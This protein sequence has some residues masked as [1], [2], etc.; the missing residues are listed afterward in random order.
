[1]AISLN[2]N[3]KINAGKP[4]DVKYLR[5]DNTPYTS[6]S[7]VNSSISA[8]E[9]HIGLTVNINGTEY[10]YNSGITDG[11]L[12]EKQTSLDGTYIT[13]ATNIGF[14]SGNTGVMTL[15]IQMVSFEN[16]SG[17]YRSQ[18]GYFYRSCDNKICVGTPTYDCINRR[19]FVKSGDTAM[20]F[21]WNESRCGNDEIGWGLIEGDVNELIGCSVELALPLYYEGGLSPYL[22][23]GFTTTI[24]Y[25]NGSNLIIQPVEGS[26][27]TGDIITI[28][29]RPYIETN[30]NVLGF[31]SIISDTPNVVNVTDDGAFIRLS[32]NSNI[33]NT[34]TASNISVSGGTGI[35]SG[36]T[37]NVLYFKPLIPSGNTIIVDNGDSVIINTDSPNPTYD[38][39]TPS[40]ITLGGIT[41][42]T[43]LT[44][45]TSFELFEMLLFPTLYPTLTP[46]SST[47]SL[48]VNSSPAASV[49]EI[50]CVLGNTCLVTSYNRGCINP[51]YT[52]ASDKR[53]CGSIGYSLTGDS[54]SG[55]CILNSLSL[56]N[57]ISGY[58]VESGTHTWSSQVCYCEGVQPY[59]NKENPYC[60][61]LSRGMTSARSVSFN[62]ILPWYWGLSSSFIINGTC[63][64]SCG[65]NGL[66]SKNLANVTSSP[67]SITFNSSS[68]DYLWFALP[69]CAAEKTCWYIPN[70]SSKGSIG[71]AES[72][73]ASYCT[74]NVTSAEGCW[75]S[76][77]Y[78]V[79]VSNYTTATEA[80]VA[81][82]IC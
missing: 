50:G 24:S 82:Y 69:A 18:Y 63:I 29:A 56:C 78:E 39:S 28:G 36:M 62:G 72:L 32:G 38:L 49:Y 4:I 3:I 22:N 61:P 25:N 40:S 16:Y 51:Q 19:G 58:V 12:I 43:T 30:D 1:M 23:T 44:G 13:G 67:I 15:P 55:Y 64:A 45:K 77:E 80:G 47:T 26:L 21:I 48:V 81:I 79:Y 2:D 10:W 54:V 53:S 14:F 20:S 70:T 6:I 27:N 66:G 37:S 76:C 42:G 71:G 46:P 60:T 59:D 65:R 8:G 52:S 74:V 9:R 11:D 7:E 17:D 33:V 34:T 41:A 57:D 31:R 5:S 73:F 68:S 35:Y 75:N